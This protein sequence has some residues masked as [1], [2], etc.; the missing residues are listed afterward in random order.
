MYYFSVPPST[1]RTGNFNTLIK[2]VDLKQILTET[3]APWQSP[4]K[5][6]R[7]EPAHVLETVKKI[8]EIKNL[9]V[10]EVTDR[11]WK[12]YEKVFGDSK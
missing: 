8:A 3:D 5:G 11:I 1:A 12:N 6:E 9:S 2:K 10:E 7:C 4:Y